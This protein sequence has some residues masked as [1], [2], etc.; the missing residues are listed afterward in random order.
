[1]KS[2]LWLAAFGPFKVCLLLSVLQWLHSM[3]WH[4]RGISTYIVRLLQ[5][6]GAA[7][8]TKHP[9]VRGQ[10]VVKRYLLVNY[11]WL[12]KVDLFPPH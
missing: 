6:Q 2:P 7:Y 11:R 3:H 9:T 12:L 4:A 5:R 10:A 1:M 8:V